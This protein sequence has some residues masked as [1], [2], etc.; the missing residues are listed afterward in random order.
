VT[1]RK[2]LSVYG[3]RG[4]RVRVLVDGD[5][6]RA[7]WY[8]AGVR[9][10][11]SW[12]NTP[13]NRV[14]AKE[15]ARAFADARTRGPAP[16]SA[17]RRILR[18]LWVLYVAAEFPHLRPRTRTL[19]AGRWRRWEA[20][21]GPTFV[22][23]DTTQ[24]HADEFRGRLA[25]AGVAVNQARNAVA[26][27]RLVYGWAERRELL[28]RNRL[29]GY[30]FKVAKDAPRNDPDEYRVDEWLAMLAV[31]DYRNPGQW[32][33]W[34]LLSLLGHQGPRVN[35]ALH[36]RWEDVDLDA[37]TVTWRSGW[38][39]MGKELTQPLR[40]GAVA[41]LLTAR[42]WRARDGYTGP[43]V[44]YSSH[45]RNGD[46]AAYKVQSFWYHLR[47]AED[48]AGVVHRPLRAA[49]GFRKMVAGEVAEATGDPWLALGFIGDDDIRM[50]RRYVKRRDDRLAAVAA[51]LDG[52]VA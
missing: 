51:Q 8:E 2:T 34:V 42:A 25:Q 3:P 32:R 52:G 9:R 40:W 38:D 13:E 36:L 31:L 49:H 29:A 33:P 24:E 19:Y 16:A 17:P 26:V 7:Q 12:A 45:R 22:A 20:F 41:A 11:Q 15:W 6:V 4:L 43:W 48:A 35:A 37:G 44:F 27:V 46:A 18:E 1:A 10:V 21:L 50:V 47:A 5:L 28:A 14:T 30:R 39:K 23:E